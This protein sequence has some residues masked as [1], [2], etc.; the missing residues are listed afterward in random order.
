MGGIV[1]I[2]LRL[3]FDFDCELCFGLNEPWVKKKVGKF[4]LNPFPGKS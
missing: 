4:S 1:L 2:S 3:C